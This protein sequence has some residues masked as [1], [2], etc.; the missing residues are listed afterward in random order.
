[1]SYMHGREGGGAQIVC[2]RIKNELCEFNDVMRMRMRQT[3]QNRLADR[4]TSK[5][6]ESF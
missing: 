4:Q 2:T 5:Q 3:K 6:F 1:M